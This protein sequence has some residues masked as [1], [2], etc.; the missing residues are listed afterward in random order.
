MQEKKS[1]I[2]YSLVIYRKLKNIQNEYTV[3][4]CKHG[5]LKEESEEYEIYNSSF[6]EG[7]EGNGLDLGGK[8]ALQSWC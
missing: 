5:K 6:I 1:H 8:Q 2:I 7:R 4:G 3:Q